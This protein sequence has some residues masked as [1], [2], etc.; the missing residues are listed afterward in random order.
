MMLKNL[1]DKAERKERCVC[2][3]D[4]EH[5]MQQSK[6][7]EE[8]DTSEINKELFDNKLKEEIEL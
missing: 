5:F 1:F 4:L 2:K 8:E 7:H 6:S 3:I